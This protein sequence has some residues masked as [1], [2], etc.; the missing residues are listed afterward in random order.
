MSKKIIVV[1]LATLVAA[2]AALVSLTQAQQTKIYRIGVIL[3]GGPYYAAVD[4]LKEGLKELGF[5]EG[6]QYVLEIRDL[7]GNRKA[8]A[9][10]LGHHSR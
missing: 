8:A 9:S 4:G 2:L 6:Q 3:E 10:Y 7:K 5:G 1:L